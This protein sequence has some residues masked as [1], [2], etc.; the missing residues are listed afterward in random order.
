MEHWMDTMILYKFQ[1]FQQACKKGKSKYF[2]YGRMFT[3]FYMGVLK[4]GMLINACS[5]SLA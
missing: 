2:L 1:I 4:F 5:L 3:S